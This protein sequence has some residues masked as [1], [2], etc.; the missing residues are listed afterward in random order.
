MAI[1]LV[2]NILTKKEKRSSK[3]GRD[4]EATVC[5]RAIETLGSYEREMTA[6]KRKM[7]EALLQNN[8][9]EVDN[10]CIK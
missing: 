6:I 8:V 3:R 4:V 1:R 10:L 7:S 9:E 2:R 5:R